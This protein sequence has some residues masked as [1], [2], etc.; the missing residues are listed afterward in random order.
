MLTGIEH[1]RMIPGFT[2]SNP[3]D[4]YDMPF[5]RSLVAAVAEAGRSEAVIIG[6]AVATH[7]ALDLVVHIHDLPVAGTH[8]TKL[9]VGLWNP[10]SSPA[11]QPSLGLT[12]RVGRRVRRT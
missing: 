4:L 10:A 1:L 7:F 5:S 6:L 2:E 12:P 9:G 11:E 3:L 8:G